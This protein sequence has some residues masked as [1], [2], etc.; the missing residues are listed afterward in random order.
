MIINFVPLIFPLEFLKVQKLV[1]TTSYFQVV[2]SRENE[3]FNFLGYFVIY[4]PISKL[5]V[6][7][8]IV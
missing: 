8:A 4:V 1:S 3:F 6:Y 7:N 2:L 5:H